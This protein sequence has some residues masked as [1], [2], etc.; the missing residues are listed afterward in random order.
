MTTE[1]W[2]HHLKPSHSIIPLDLNDV[3]IP[4]FNA[5]LTITST[6]SSA[7]TVSLPPLGSSPR[8][9]PPT[10]SH[11]RQPSHSAAPKTSSKSSKS[12]SSKSS[13]SSSSSKKSSAS[14]HPRTSTPPLETI[15]PDFLSQQRC[16]RCTAK[17]VHVSKPSSSRPQ[18]AV[19]RWGAIP[20]FKP[21]GHPAEFVYH[22][23]E[24]LSDLRP[25]LVARWE[26]EQKR[27]R[28]ESGG[29]QSGGGSGSEWVNERLRDS[30]VIEQLVY[31]V[32]FLDE[33][34][35]YREPSIF[36]E[37]LFAGQPP[38]VPFQECEHCGGRG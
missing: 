15:L 26:D 30:W 7:S 2:K 24:L 33:W 20:Y 5:S 10:K 11:S 31:W 14:L 38:E 22:T 32:E 9:R 12:S 35:S 34:K 17:I 28:R 23:S 25:D 1:H 6:A 18:T 8:M 3:L 29:R 37:E 16:A 36:R 27:H 19:V 21:T 4:A 13:S